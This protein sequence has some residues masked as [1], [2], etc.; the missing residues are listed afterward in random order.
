M[1]SQFIELLLAMHLESHMKLKKVTGREFIVPLDKDQ[2]ETKKS[3]SKLLEAIIGWD[4]DHVPAVNEHRSI[5][6]EL[7][8]DP[9][10]LIWPVKPGLMIGI[11]TSLEDQCAPTSGK[12]DLFF[13]VQHG[14]FVLHTLWTGHLADC[15][16]FPVDILK[17][18]TLDVL[19]DIVNTGGHVRDPFGGSFEHALLPLLRIV[20]HLLVMGSLDAND[21]STV[22]CLL[23]PQAFPLAQNWR[24]KII[25]SLLDLPL[26]ESVKLE[27][28]HLF[29]NLCDL[30][31]R[32]RIE[33]VIHFANTAVG[34]IQNVRV[35]L[36]RLSR[37]YRL[38]FI[39][40]SFLFLF[41]FVERT[42]R[43]LRF[44]RLAECCAYQYCGI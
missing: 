25:G 24:T 19:I 21:L 38:T 7:V 9:H 14:P 30:R 1:R 31:L 44:E 28:C 10:L 20:N 42:I 17:K 13:M 12:Y 27:V 32:H 11:G 37:A 35:Y 33:S 26:P 36:L 16:P 2:L 29:Q 5:R 15:P 23:N 3:R 6:P 41:M 22:L 34:E 39:P 43:G 8:T 18:Q 4:P 40:N